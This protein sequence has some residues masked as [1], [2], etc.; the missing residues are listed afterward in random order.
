MIAGVYDYEF[1][2]PVIILAAPRSGSTLLFE[3]L[4]QSRDFWT[5]G[6]ESHGV[7]EAIG[8]YD[9]DYGLCNSNRLDKSDVDQESISAIRQLFFSALR[10]R[11]GKIFGP[12]AS[13]PRFL[14]KTPKNSLR[15]PFIDELF[16]D[17][18]YIY[19]YRNP[20]ENV[21]SIIEAWNSGRFVTYRNLSGLGRDWSL[22]L[23]PGWE[24]M[25]GKEV[26]EIAAYQWEVANKTIINDLISYIPPG[27][28]TTIGYA[29]LVNNTELEIERLCRFC[30]VDFDSQLRAVCQ[31]SL[32][33]SQYTLSQPR[34]DKWHKYA[35]K[36]KSVLPSLT[37]TVE[38]IKE[39]SGSKNMQDFDLSIDGKLIMEAGKIRIQSAGFG[40]RK[41]GR[42]EPCPCG[43]GKKYK[44]CHG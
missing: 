11:T 19:L 14:E 28:R 7:F 33:M 16:P 41:I 39:M 32:K 29:D 4:T 36:L 42:N 25:K 9:P 5:I 44:R 22:L 2:R 12:G 43:S 26:Y 10:D 1:D 34:T 40:G 18:L 15:V 30:D 6:G 31:G 20:R 3:T 38:R 13:K 17:A 27:R 35:D 21:A 23:P 37:D 8:K 24:S